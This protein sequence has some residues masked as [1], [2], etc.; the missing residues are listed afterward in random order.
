MLGAKANKFILERM[1]VDYQL[2]LLLLVLSLFLTK[3]ANIDEL[4]FFD[5]RN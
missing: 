2:T 5:S 4:R 3:P 1:N